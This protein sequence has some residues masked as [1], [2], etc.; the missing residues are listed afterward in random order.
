MQ[1]ILYMYLFTYGSTSVIVSRR[2]IQRESYI[3][4]LPSEEGDSVYIKSL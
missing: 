2:G 4:K 3:V 1:V